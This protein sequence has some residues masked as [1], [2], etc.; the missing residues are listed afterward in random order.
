MSVKLKKTLLN[1]DKKQILSNCAGGGMNYLST[2][3]LG[4]EISNAI[5]MCCLLKG[6]RI[7][8]PKM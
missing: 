4:N 3:S 8:S 2:L 1:N 6:Q 5:K 7:S